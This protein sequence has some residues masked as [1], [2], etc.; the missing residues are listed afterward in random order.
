MTYMINNIGQYYFNFNFNTNGK[1]HH[2]KQK[3]QKYF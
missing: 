1:R 3:R 2:S